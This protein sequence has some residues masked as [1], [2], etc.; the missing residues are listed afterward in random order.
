MAVGGSGGHFS[1]DYFEFVLIPRFPEPR[2]HQ[3]ARLYH[4]PA[5]RPAREATLTNFV[6][7]HREW[8][9]GLGI[10]ELDRELKALQRTLACRQEEII[11]GRSVKLPF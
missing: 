9:E 2:Q 11:E 10:W 7:W 1:P 6:T 3:I 5:P 4:N 8:N